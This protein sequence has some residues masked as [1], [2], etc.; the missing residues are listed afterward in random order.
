M[1]G[2]FGPADCIDFSAIGKGMTPAAAIVAAWG[3]E[4]G[5]SDEERDAARRF[6][7]QWPEGPQVAERW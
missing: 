4:P 3:N 6:L 1:D 7:S 5:R 2:D